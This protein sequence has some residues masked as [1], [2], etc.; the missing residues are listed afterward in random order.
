MSGEIEP[1]QTDWLAI[2]LKDRPSEL[3]RRY[4]LLRRRTLYE[5]WDIGRGLAVIREDM[6]GRGRGAW[7]EWL[8]SVGIERRTAERFLVIAQAEMRQIVAFDDAKL[9]FSEAVKLIPKRAPLGQLS[10]ESALAEVPAPPPA[11]EPPPWEVDMAADV[12]EVAEEAAAEMAAEEAAARDTRLD[13]RLEGSDADAVAH[14]ADKLDAEER[15]NASLR[16][17]AEEEHERFRGC[18]RSHD[19]V[20]AA[21]IAIPLSADAEECQDAIAAILAAEYGRGRRS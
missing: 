3:S 14:L 21:L 12:E 11:H 7:G 20:R 15:R 16:L 5:S 8:E 10:R 17:S 18:M 19:R 9:P 13:L 6:R 4:H 2:H 1:V